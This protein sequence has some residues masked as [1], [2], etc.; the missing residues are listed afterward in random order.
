MFKIIGSGSDLEPFPGSGTLE[1]LELDPEYH[2]KETRQW[3][4]LV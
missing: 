3:K 4:S 1:E 2:S